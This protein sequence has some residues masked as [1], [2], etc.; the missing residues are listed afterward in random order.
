MHFQLY[1]LK[2]LNSKCRINQVVQHSTEPAIQHLHVKCKEKIEGK[3]FTIPHRYQKNHH[4]IQPESKL[5]IDCHLQNIVTI[6]L[7]VP[8]VAAKDTDFQ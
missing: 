4:V 1:Y 5:K 2:I 7:C 8:P 6:V 3:P